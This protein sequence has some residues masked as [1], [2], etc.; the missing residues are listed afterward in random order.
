[1]FQIKNCPLPKNW[2]YFFCLIQ[3]RKVKNNLFLEYSE[4]TFILRRYINHVIFRLVKNWEKRFACSF[5]YKLISFPYITRKQIHAQSYSSHSR[6][7]RRLKNNLVSLKSSKTSCILCDITS[8]VPTHIILSLF[9]SNSHNQL[10]QM[11]STMR[12]SQVNLLSSFSFMC[13]LN[14]LL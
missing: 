9:I 12:I 10:W 4:K 13:R 11:K 6:V 5:I 14:N 2:Y 3:K 8:L 7:E 1:M